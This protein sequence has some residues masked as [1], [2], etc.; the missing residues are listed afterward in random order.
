MAELN[1]VQAYTL[2]DFIRSFRP[3][4]LGHIIIEDFEGIASGIAFEEVVCDLCNVEIVQPEEKPFKP[5]IFL[6][7]GCGLCEDCMQRMEDEG[8][9]PSLPFSLLT[10]T[11]RKTSRRNRGRKG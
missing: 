7:D 8:E 2:E 6:T 3:D 4:G 11:S 10:R 1:E 9:K 5:V